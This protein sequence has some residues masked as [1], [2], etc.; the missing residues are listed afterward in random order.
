MRAG[1]HIAS[2]IFSMVGYRWVIY[3][4]P[5]DKNPE[6][7][8]LYVSMFVALV[9][10]GTDVRALFK[11]NLM[12]QSGKGKHKV[13]S[14]FNCPLVSELYTLKYCGSM[15]PNIE[16]VRNWTQRKWRQKGKLEVVA[17]KDLDLD[18][19]LSLAPPFGGPQIADLLTVVREEF[20]LS[21]LL[22]TN[23]NSIN[24]EFDGDI[25][26]SSYARE[27]VEVR[28]VDEDK[29]LLLGENMDGGALVGHTVEE[30]EEETHPALVFCAP[31][32]EEVDGSPLYE[33]DF[34]RSMMMPSYYDCPLSGPRF[35]MEFPPLEKII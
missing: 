33:Y 17:L 3:L 22:K 11:L 13:Q 34:G 2:E 32:V 35:E 25:K 12:D 24:E 28:S 14:H 15:W 16:A 19:V 20:K 1:K 9:S 8:S 6:D 18:N 26:D 31:G 29:N 4:Y 5:D 27:D 10:K 30:V 23:Q 7:N 21:L